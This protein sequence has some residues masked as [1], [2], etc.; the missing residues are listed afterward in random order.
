[1]R[2]APWEMVMVNTGLS[3]SP[4]VTVAPGSPIT[5]DLAPAHK[6]YVLSANISM[7][8]GGLE[9]TSAL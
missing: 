2:T 1:M 6:I 8:L 3:D 9:F 5:A 4:W 7:I